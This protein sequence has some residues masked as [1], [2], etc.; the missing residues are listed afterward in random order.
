MSV[1][2]VLETHNN[3]NTDTGSKRKRNHQP[4]LAIVLRD[5]FLG[6]LVKLQEC[7]SM[8]FSIQHQNAMCSLQFFL[9]LLDVEWIAFEHQIL[10]VI[11]KGLLMEEAVS[12]IA[13]QICRFLVP[14][15]M[16]PG[17]AFKLA[18]ALLDLVRTNN[19]SSS[20]S[21]SSLLT[22]CRIFFED[23][24]L[25][26]PLSQAPKEL[27]VFGAATFCSVD[28]SY[29]LLVPSKKRISFGDYLRELDCFLDDSKDDE[30]M[31]ETILSFFRIGI[32]I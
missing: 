18:F 31:S 15:Q 13:V 25:N 7:L 19:T 5:C 17:A 2:K 32:F 11:K 6:I 8:P 16:S 10:V 20:S 3:S 27:F 28:F 24:F 22:Q 12:E 26:I 4:S 23:I 21:S 9:R 14:L 29:L 30:F 1:S